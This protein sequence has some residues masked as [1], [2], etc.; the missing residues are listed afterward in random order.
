[1]MQELILEKVFFKGQEVEA[2]VM[3]EEYLQEELIY[4]LVDREFYLCDGVGYYRKFICSDSQLWG[5]DCPC[6][7]HD[8]VVWQKF[9]PVSGFLG[10]EM[11]S[12]GGDFF[13]EPI[14]KPRNKRRS[15]IAK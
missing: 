11:F 6:S 7:D 13:Q 1:M 3:D 15:T 14:C 9:D 12:R 10:R 4:G 2:R 5:G 8:P